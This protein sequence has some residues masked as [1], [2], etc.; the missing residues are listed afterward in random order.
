M[1]PPVYTLG[2]APRATGLVRSPLAFNS[3]LS[4]EKEFSLSSIHEGMN[5]ELRLEAQNAFNHPVFGTPDT[6]VDDPNFGIIS[7]TSNSPRQVQLGLK[8]T[9]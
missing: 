6:S 4:V 7:Y 5:F 8:V 1:L 9:F 2:D 3:S